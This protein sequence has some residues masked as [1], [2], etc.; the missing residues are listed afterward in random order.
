VRRSAAADPVPGRHLEV[1][2][3]TPTLKELRR[4]NIGRQSFPVL[5]LEVQIEGTENG[6]DLSAGRIRL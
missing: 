2:G 5:I 1:P 3:S 6:T 4:Q